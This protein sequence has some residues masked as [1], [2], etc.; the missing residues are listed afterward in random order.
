MAQTVKSTSSATSKV[1]KALGVF[2]S[3]QVV[4]ILCSVI[5]TKLVALWIG[6]AGVG[7]IT[8]YNST[9][10]LISNTTQLNLRQSAV[11]DISTE[12]DKAK[13]IA[14]TRKIAFVLGLAGMLLTL[15]ASPLLS[16][17][18]FG[19]TAHTVA[20]AAL[21][22]MMLL[23]AVASGEWAVMQGLERLKLL[24]RSTLLSSLT[25]T[26]AAI[27]LFYFFRIDGI[28]PVL[29]IFAASNCLYAFVL[30]VRDV[31]QIRLSLRQSWQC[32]RG[33][34]ALGFYMTVSMAL[35]LLASYVFAVWLFHQ[36]GDKA[37]G[38]YQ[39]GYTLVNSYVGMIFTAIAMEY[40]PR[41]AAVA[42]SRMRTELVV[43][44]E[45]K[46]ALL[47]LMP[48][49]VL[50]VACK[51][52]VIYLLY[53]PDFYA[54]LPYVSLAIVGVI[55]RG[56]SWCMAYAILAR[57]DGRIYVFTELASAVVYLALNIPLYSCYGYAGLGVAYIAWFAIYTA[58]CYGVYR[59]RYGLRLRGGVAA[60]A[61]VTLA[62]SAVALWLDSIFG[63]V[64]PLI[65]FVP[66][67]AYAV[68]RLR[69][70]LI[71]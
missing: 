70:M 8:L 56:L 23:S 37:V 12:A 62:V 61:V 17:F 48:V 29:I 39:S 35:T 58:V 66:V 42:K 64:A 49:I 33:M 54:A 71:A 67:A 22:V 27:P 1:L 44:H 28:V 10:D 68:C 32:G 43:S 47:V 16:I 34:L 13:V 57:G 14:V 63:F 21:S 26:A 59:K 38:I 65:F 46:I 9:V 5:R 7:L 25:A 45:I 19:D 18:T 52:A 31:P 20:F 15:A 41:L 30:R 24:A 2:G 50:F 51:E 11:R 60:L 40:Y 36:G 3:V 55:F 69:A 4:T 53:S 6:P